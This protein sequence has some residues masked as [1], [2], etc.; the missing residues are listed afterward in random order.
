[1]G[2]AENLALLKKANF[3]VPEFFIFN[4]KTKTPILKSEKL[5][6]RS[7]A[8]LEDSPEHSFA[9]IFESKVINNNRKEIISGVKEVLSAFSIAKIDS[10]LKNKGIKQEIRPKIFIQEYIE[11]DISGVIFTKYRKES[12]IGTLINYNKTF[13]T[14]QGLV[15]LFFLLR[16]SRTAGLN[17]QSHHLI[18]N[19]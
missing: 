10:Y 7:S 3:N 6:I 18:S 4:P 9:G 13:C 14:R 11:G 12:K 8:S 5:I 19:I 15:Q 16:Y 17:F 1:M 2:K